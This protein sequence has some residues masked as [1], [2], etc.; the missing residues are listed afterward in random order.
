MLDNFL[1][2]HTTTH[3]DNLRVHQQSRHSMTT[4]KWLDIF[5]SND[6]PLHFSQCLVQSYLMCVLLSLKILLSKISNLSV[7]S[8]QIHYLPSTLLCTSTEP[9]PHAYTDACHPL[10]NPGHQAILVSLFSYSRQDPLVHRLS[11]AF[12]TIITQANIYWNS[13]LPHFILYMEFSL[14]KKQMK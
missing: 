3:V 2:S 13:H 5:R 12:V 1:W 4:S 7:L 9:A 10:I 8:P 6:F 14:H 11:Y